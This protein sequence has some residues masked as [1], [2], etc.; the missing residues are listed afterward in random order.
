MKGVIEPTINRSLQV[1]LPMDHN[2]QRY[3][4]PHQKRS[5]SKDSLNRMQ[6][7]FPDF[8]LRFDIALVWS[9]TLSIERTSTGVGDWKRVSS[10]VV[11]GLYG[12]GASSNHYL[13]ISYF[14]FILFLFLFVSI[15]CCCWKVLISDLNFRKS[16]IY[17]TLSLSIFIWNIQNH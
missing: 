16:I 11:S 7:T 2:L 13:F 3:P 12:T 1:S 8:F 5:T 9:F 17:S 4:P 14:L 15:F 6:S 10:K